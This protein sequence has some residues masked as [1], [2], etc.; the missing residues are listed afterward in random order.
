MAQTTFITGQ[1]VCIHQTAATIV[2]RMLAFVIDG[3]ILL[4]ALAVISGILT[5]L[6]L[7][8]FETNLYGFVE[9]LLIVPFLTYPLWMEYFFNGQTLGKR[10]MRIR[11]VCLD[12]SRPSF[13]AFMLRWVLLLVELPFGVGILFA[14]FTKNSQRIGDLAANTTVVQVS[15]Q[16]IPSVINYMPF[17][18]KGYTPTYPE[19][20]ALNMRQV[21][22]MERVLYNYDGYQRM[23][24]LHQLAL[25]LE[26]MLGVKS[27][28]LDDEH[29]VNK[30][31]NDFH[32]FATKVL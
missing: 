8:Y 12:G 23:E 19:A 11:V 32:Y 4:L 31:C 22:V 30:L 2:Q 28:D 24:Y 13:S 5:S 16:E 15:S 9:F 18:S 1:H 21:E 6:L 14:I 20:A 25:K 10:I 17:A 27:K 26:N 3:F 29:F 7:A